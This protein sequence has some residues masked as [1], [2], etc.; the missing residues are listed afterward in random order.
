[1]SAK[2][3]A[4]YAL[5]VQTIKLVT[6][7]V[8]EAPA[9]YVTRPDDMA[10]TFKAFIGDYDRE[11][12]AV[13]LLNARNKIIGLHIVS[14]GTTTCAQFAVAEVFKAAL[15]ANAACIML[16][17]NHPSGDPTPSR[18]DI[19]ATKNIVTCGDI[20]GIPVVDHVVV[21]ASG[22]YCSMRERG[23]M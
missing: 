15:L 7:K 3:P 23:L 19:N 17:H 22:P 10:A 14:I 18:Q 12:L 11:H 8:C 4:T 2:K 9:Q 6:E 13:A 20:L 5:P 21:T 16:G 1:M